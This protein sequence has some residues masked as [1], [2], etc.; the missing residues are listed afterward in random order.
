MTF[1]EAFVDELGKIAQAAPPPMGAGPTPIPMAKTAP[2]T[3]S[4][5]QIG[6][7]QARKRMAIAPPGL[8]TGLSPAAQ[9]MRG[10]AA[11]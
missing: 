11:V 8:P 10:A 3:T 6:L 7:A 5:A 2:L 4:S 1:F 9:G